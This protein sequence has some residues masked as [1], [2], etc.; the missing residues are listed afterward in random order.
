MAFTL[1]VIPSSPLQF[2][3]HYFLFVLCFGLCDLEASQ[4]LD[5]E[6]CSLKIIHPQG[7][8]W[9]HMVPQYFLPGSV[10]CGCS[11]TKG[12]LHRGWRIQVVVGC[13]KEA[14]GLWPFQMVMWWVSVSIILPK[15]RSCRGREWGELISAYMERSHSSW[16]Q[17]S[18]KGNLSPRERWLMV[19]RGDVGVW[20]QDVSF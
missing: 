11:V 18:S 1:L 8:V 15:V 5:P 10:A 12:T 7:R 13:R 9:A 3:F 19:L 6:S 16:L 2:G 20:Q 17:Q 4:T 14:S